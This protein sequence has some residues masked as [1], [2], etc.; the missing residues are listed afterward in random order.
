MRFKNILFFV[1]LFLL[2]ACLKKP[3]S[4]KGI[5]FVS[6][7][8]VLD[9]SY[10]HDIQSRYLDMHIHFSNSDK[11][12]RTFKNQISQ[13]ESRLKKQFIKSLDEEK[14]YFTSTD[15]RNIQRRLTGILKK[16]ERQDCSELDGIYNLYY[17]RVSQRIDF[18]K[19]YLKDFQMD[20]SLSIVLDPKK[21]KRFRT[22]S[23]V[24]KFYGRYI[25]YRVANAIVASSEKTYQEQLAEAKKNLFSWLARLQKRVQ[26]WSV[27]LSPAQKKSCMKR[28]NFTTDQ[29]YFCKP[30]KWY[31]IYLDSFARSLDPHSGY[32]SQEDH[33]EFE[34]N[35]QLSLEGIG[36][37]LYNRYGHTTI[38]RLLPGGAAARSGKLKAKD[39]ILAVGQARSKLVNVFDM[40][41]RDVVSL[42]RGRKGTPVYLKIL[43]SVKKNKILK[44]KKTKSKKE[45]KVF[46]V[47][48]IRDRISLKDQAASVFYFDRPL[49]K[50]DGRTKKVAVLMVP[51]FYV[52]G[53]LGGRS[54]SRDIKKLLKEVRKKKVDALVLDLSGNGGGALSEAVRVAGLFFSRGN[55][56]RQLVKTKNGDRYLTLSDV[57]EGVEYTGP[58]VVL[59]NRGSA[60]ASEIV[61][62]TMKSYRRAV[63]VGGDHTFGKGSIQ[64]VEPLGKG[65]G[66]IRVTVGLFFIP[67]GF[68][69]QLKGV[70]SDIHFPSVYSTE[71]WGEKNLD[72]VLSGR[73]IPEFVSDSAYTF[74]REKN[75]FK[76]VDAS[77]IQ[78]LKKRSESRIRQTKKFLD[79]END[80][81]KMNKKRS[82]G[83]RVRISEIFDEAKKEEEKEGTEI[84][85]DEDGFPRRKTRD[86]LKK[87]YRE[88]ADIQEAVNIAID[89]VVQNSKPTEVATSHNK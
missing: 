32:L 13:L 38:E 86:D 28:K 29:A 81:A 52:E 56:V 36:A 59:V 62:G 87:E 25:Q 21:R 8:R 10:I 45:N 55:V 31:A 78:W 23:G 60:S 83:F 18:A 72:Y 43:R 1:F 7:S 54:V 9:C 71:Q 73:K 68:S 66:S 20:P 11:K 15:V 5:Q 61:A 4:I 74:Q 46:T 35:M 33:E 40:D 58:M 2:S 79:I 63:I 34:I 75:K 70:P 41:L 65:F 76:P 42:I 12:K 27:N 30:Y 89:M 51:S 3:Q 53:R 17:K 85:K 44:E 6:S 80:I 47:R 48:V 77:L 50:G 14:V 39:R 84:T 49:K 26:S 16:V 22:S 88:R 19:K 67:N 64:S 37:T 24:N 57:D 69:T 82:T